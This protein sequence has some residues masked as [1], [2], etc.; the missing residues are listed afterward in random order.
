MK[1]K[2]FK[3][4]KYTAMRKYLYILFAL[5]MFLSSFGVWGQPNNTPVS[6]RWNNGGQAVKG[7]FIQIGNIRNFS[8]EAQSSATLKV[9]THSSCLRV[10]WAGLYWSAYVPIGDRHNS[11]IEQVKFK[12]PGDTQFRD[13]RADVHMYSNFANS[14]DSYNCFKDVTSLLQSKGANFN[15]GEYTVSGIYSP[16]TIGSWGGWTLIVVY[17]DIQAATSKKI[18]IYD[19]A[20]W[21]FFNYNGTQTKTI[22][23]TGFQT[24]PAPAPIKARMG[25]FTGAG[26]KGTSYTAGDE[27][28]INEVKQGQA[29]NPNA[30]NDFMDETISFNHSEAAMPRNP[31]VTNHI[32]IDIFDIPNPNNSVIKN[33]DTS[34]TIK[35]VASDAYITYTVALSVDAIAPHI[36]T[37][38]E[39]LGLENAQWK[40]FTGKRSSIVL[41]FVI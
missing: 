20:E 13:L 2:L 25:I 27:I 14:G 9:P 12:M 23:I 1:T 18:Y 36:E 35:F 30:Y 3:T 37:H 5:C 40:D 28:R 29:S 17:E 39:V 33:G 8:T 41:S 4:K 31:S 7:D 24:P 32:D 10:K 38:K 26:D 19:G 21:N 11:R 34:L 16:N 6:L 22:P 15:N